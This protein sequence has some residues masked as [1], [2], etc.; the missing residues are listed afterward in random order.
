MPKRQLLRT[1][2]PTNMLT[3]ICAL[4]FAW[5]ISCWVFMPRFAKAQE[6]IHVKGQYLMELA[7]Q[8]NLD[9]VG[10]GYL[11][12][13]GAYLNPH[14]SLQ[15]GLSRNNFNACEV[16]EHWLIRPGEDSVLFKQSVKKPYESWELIGVYGQK[17]LRLKE[18]LYL[19]GLVGASFGLEKYGKDLAWSPAYGPVL[20]LEMELFYSSRFSIA[21]R[22]F[23]QYL[24]N[25]SIKTKS[26]L[27]VGMRFLISP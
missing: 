7:Y 8:I 5:Q 17:L 16:H 14:S 22:Y 2:Y 11:F 27:Q 4:V 3:K 24:P 6:L 9:Q 18:F 15:L 10:Y 23:F 19:K 26:H 21:S 13:A 12:S 1:F 25:S 20:G